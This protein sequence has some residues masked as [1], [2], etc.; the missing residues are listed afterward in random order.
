MKRFLVFLGLALGMVA[1]GTNAKKSAEQEPIAIPETPRVVAAIEADFCY[2]SDVANS[3]HMAF[4]YDSEGRL[5]R[6]DATGDGAN[7]STEI[8]YAEEG[9]VKISELPF[10]DGGF[11]TDAKGYCTSVLSDATKHTLYAYDGA[12][13]LASYNYNWIYN[14]AER[15]EE[16][17]IMVWNDKN[18]EKSLWRL[19]WGTEAYNAKRSYEYNAGS[20][21]ATNLD[22]NWL[23]EPKLFNIDFDV[24]SWNPGMLCAAG[25]MGARSENHLL[26]SSDEGKDA[27]NAKFD[28]Q[29]DAEGYP[30]SCKVSCYDVNDD[31]NKPYFTCT[32]TFEYAE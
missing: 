29:Y 6:C 16:E 17:S 31:K 24:N 9:V 25:F 20:N 2:G 10:N 30:T 26:S 22:L 19:N 4:S 23:V 7:S 3:Y 11:R 1:C 5:V 32:Y 13:R 12:G 28:W 14:N 21:Y 8:C 15:V 27:L 18:L